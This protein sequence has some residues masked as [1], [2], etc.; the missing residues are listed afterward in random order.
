L[1]PELMPDAELV[2]PD[3]RGHPPF[4][5]VRNRAVRRNPRQ[6]EAARAEHP[7]C[8]CVFDV[9]WWNGQDVRSWPLLERKVLLAELL[10]TTGT[11][12]RLTW[13]ETR[14]A[15]LFKQACELDLEGIVA[16]RMDAPYRAGRQDAWRKIRNYD[17]S[18]GAALSSKRKPHWPRPSP[19]R[20]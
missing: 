1:L 13:L 2:V 6:I 19:A 15:A 14:G 17:Y 18:R 7:A 5:R 4:D 10:P 16:K 9:L 11:V 8:L 20:E 12:H 3:E